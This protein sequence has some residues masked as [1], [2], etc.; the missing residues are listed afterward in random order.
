MDLE[1]PEIFNEFVEGL[2][3][4]ILKRELNG[5]RTEMWYLIKNRKLGLIDDRMSE[6]SNVTEGKAKEVSWKSIPSTRSNF[7][8]LT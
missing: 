1:E 8:V 5:N 7:N 4:R 2:K 3:G 6:L